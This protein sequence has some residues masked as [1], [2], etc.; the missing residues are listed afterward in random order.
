MRQLEWSHK[1]LLSHFSS[2]YHYLPEEACHVCGEW[3][4]WRPFGKNMWH[5]DGIED[6]ARDCCDSCK[7][8]V[9]AANF[10]QILE[11]E[12]PKW[13]TLFSAVLL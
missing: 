12:I 11:F 5:L 4:Y 13:P 10:Y 3:N 2:N 8:F 7:C 6:A 1:Q 9:E